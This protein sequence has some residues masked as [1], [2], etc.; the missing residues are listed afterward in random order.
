[1]VFL[2]TES[3][4]NGHIQKERKDQEGVEFGSRQ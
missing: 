2:Y 4:L 3:Q 1:M